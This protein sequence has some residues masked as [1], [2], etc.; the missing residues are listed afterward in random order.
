MSCFFSAFLGFIGVAS[1]QKLRFY[2]RK[3][4]IGKK[5]PN[6]EKVNQTECGS[7]KVFYAC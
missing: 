1:L 6:A 2:F 5:N 3:K 4:T 7:L